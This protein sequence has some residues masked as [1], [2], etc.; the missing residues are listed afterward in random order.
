MTKEIAKKAGNEKL[1]TPI[2]MKV[3][4][5]MVRG[6]KYGTIQRILEEEHDI[7]YSQKSLSHLRKNNIDVIKEM[8]LTIL[9]AQASEAQQ[10]HTKLIR[11]LNKKIDKATEDELELERL[12]EE[13]RTTDMTLTDYRRQKTGLLKISARDISQMAKDIHTQLDSKRKAVGTGSS[14]PTAPGGSEDLPG[15]G[16]DP[17]WVEGLT[18]AIQRGDTI[19]MQQLIVAPNN[20][21]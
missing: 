18:L 9:D 4:A 21:A 15:G 8:E 6:E 16:L 1:T 11:A 14:S 19:T 3:L 2:K 17:K 12:D 10:T 7:S 5:M 13:Y 20:N